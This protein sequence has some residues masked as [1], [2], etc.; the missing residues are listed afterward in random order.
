MRVISGAKGGAIHVL[1]YRRGGPG[2]AATPGSPIRKY[3]D[4][5]IDASH[6]E[7]VTL[8]LKSLEL[9]SA[10]LAAW[11]PTLGL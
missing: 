1:G 5:S 11:P 10:K 7:R 8:I 4:F 3:N 2:W 9:P 6:K